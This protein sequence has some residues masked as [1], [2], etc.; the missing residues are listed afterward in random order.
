MQIIDIEGKLARLERVISPVNALI[1]HLNDGSKRHMILLKVLKNRYFL[2]KSW[3]EVEYVLD[4][5]RRT[6]FRKNC[7]LIKLFRKFLVV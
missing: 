4:M 1:E 6:L 5:S 7:T 2:H 3:R